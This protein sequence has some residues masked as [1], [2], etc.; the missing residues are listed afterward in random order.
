MTSALYIVYV[1]HVLYA[2]YVMPRANE[3]NGANTMDDIGSALKRA[4]HQSHSLARSSCERIAWCLGMSLRNTLRIVNP[5]PKI[6]IR[7]WTLP[8][9][10]AAPSA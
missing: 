8:M 7:F 5:P 1:V 4:E 2:I 3:R 10:H 6:C 9:L